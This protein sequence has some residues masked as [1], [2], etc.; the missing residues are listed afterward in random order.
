MTNCRA[1]LKVGLDAIYH[2]LLL[3]IVIVIMPGV[4]SKD[5]LNQRLQLQLIY[6]FTKKIIFRINIVLFHHRN[7]FNFYKKNCYF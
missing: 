7:L 2:C 3:V 1:L 6:K 5:A 4:N